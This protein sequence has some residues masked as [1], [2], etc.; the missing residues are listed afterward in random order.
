VPT[1]YLSNKTVQTPTGTYNKKSWVVYNW[2]RDDLE[3]DY[4]SK[5]VAHYF[6]TWIG[7]RTM[8]ST[9]VNEMNTAQFST[10][11]LEKQKRTSKG[12]TN[13]LLRTVQ[14]NASSTWLKSMSAS[15]KAVALPLFLSMCAGLNKFHGTDSSAMLRR[16]FTI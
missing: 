8:W 6:N 3:K 7:K 11:T 16:Q 14:P 2:G 12:E 4:A 15:T 13:L 1:H 9:T 5:I 10:W